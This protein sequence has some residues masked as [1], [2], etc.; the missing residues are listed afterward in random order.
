MSKSDKMGRI[1]VLN[2]PRRAGT[3]GLVYM[4]E[5]SLRRGTFGVCAQARCRRSNRPGNSQ[6]AGTL[7]AKDSGES[8]GRARAAEGITIS[9][10]R[11]E[12]ASNRAG[13]CARGDAG[14][15]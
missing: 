1:C 8:A 10:N 2:A 7:Y 9:G 12:G 3:Y 4:G 15:T 13:F 14:E 5:P 6:A 11:T